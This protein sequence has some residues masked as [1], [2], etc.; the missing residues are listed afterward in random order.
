[1]IL[2]WMLFKLYAGEKSN[3]SISLV[4]FYALLFF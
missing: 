4:I 3:F 1:M 2:K